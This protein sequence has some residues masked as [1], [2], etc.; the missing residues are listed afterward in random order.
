MVET[1]WTYTPTDGGLRP[2]VQTTK[3]GALLLL[4]MPE[5]T[6][7]TSLRK[8]RVCV[9]MALK[10]EDYGQG[11]EC[12][13]VLTARRDANCWTDMYSLTIPSLTSVV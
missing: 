13:E 4:T 6:Q 7:W 9:T 12:Y 10:D 1:H 5:I 2:C 8:L 3:P 11:Y